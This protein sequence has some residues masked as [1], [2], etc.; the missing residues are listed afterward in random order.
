[1]CVARLFYVFL[2]FYVYVTLFGVFI[3]Y[4]GTPSYDDR[5][6][7]IYKNRALCVCTHHHHTLDDDHIAGDGA[8]NQTN[9]CAFR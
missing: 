4:T 1:M 6:T 9:R 2:H 8:Y 7:F 5:G 3:I